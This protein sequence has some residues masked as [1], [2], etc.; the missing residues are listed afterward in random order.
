MRNDKLARAIRKA[1]LAQDI[2]EW[3]EKMA[4]TVK[5]IRFNDGHEETF[6]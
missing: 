3:R 5:V 6:Q 4:A 1:Q 2:K